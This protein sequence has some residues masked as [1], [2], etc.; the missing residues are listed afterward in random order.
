MMGTME[1]LPVEPVLDALADRGQ[2][3]K[4]LGPALDRA[5]HRAQLDGGL[6]WLA[7]DKVAVALGYHPGELWPIAWWAVA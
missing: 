2:S 4:S 3:I 6:T 1:R 7:A 5:V